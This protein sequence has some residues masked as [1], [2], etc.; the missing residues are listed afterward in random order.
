[1]DHLY[2]F[3]PEQIQHVLDLQR[4]WCISYSDDEKND[5]L[6]ALQNISKHLGSIDKKLTTG[7]VIPTVKGRKEIDKATVKSLDE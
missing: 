4:G 6:K 3:S 1:M 5:I 7:V 2:L